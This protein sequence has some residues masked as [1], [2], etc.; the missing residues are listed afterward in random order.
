MAI[1]TGS[2]TALCTPFQNTGNS[3][4]PIFN[5]ESYRKL[6]EFQV[7]NGTDALV[8]CGTTGEVSTLDN[9]EHIEVA[10]VAV[11]TAKAQKR[12]IPV[13]A[14]AGGNDTRNILGLVKRLQHVG[15]DAIML[16]TPYYNKTSQRGLIEHFTMIAAATDLPIILYNVPSRT[17]LNMLPKTLYELSKLPNIVAVKEASGDIS[18]IAEVIAL[19]GENLDVYSGNDDH[20]VPVL[21][22]GGKGVISTVSNIAPQ[23]VHD[24]IISYFDGDTKTAATMQIEMLPLIRLLFA[25]VNPM[26]VKAALQMLGLEMGDCRRP[27]TKIDETLQNDLSK[28][29]KRYGLL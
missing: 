6:I 21:S 17:S 1:F 26:P 4:T 9:D 11:Q 2:G 12:K 7:Y 28:E 27:L 20:I 15:V 5:E 19:C 10:S 23:Q 29:M 25:D 14:G 16:V 3:E 8:A 18:Q 24:M 22:L 13:I